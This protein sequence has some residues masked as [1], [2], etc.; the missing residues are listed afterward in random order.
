MSESNTVASVEARE[1][2]TYED[3]AQLIE[4][5]LISPELNEEQ[6][7]AGCDVARRCGLAAVTV[8]PSDI[9]LAERWHGPSLA[10]G[11]VIDWP[12]GYSTT[13]AKQYAARD[14]L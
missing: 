3:F 10:L 5:P 4:L 1:P 11:T 2:R 7:A 8:R 6:I 12:H 9:D 14:A 13:A